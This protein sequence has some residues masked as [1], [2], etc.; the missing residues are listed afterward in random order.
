LE[1]LRQGEAAAFRDVRQA[2]AVLTLVFG[3]VLPTYRAHHADLLFH[4]REEDLFQP[5]FLAR[6][7]EAV[8]AQR[9]PWE[10]A[11]RIVRGSLR[12]L[13]DY[14]GHRPIAILESRPKG[15]PYEHERVRPIP[16]FLRGAGVAWGPYQ[17]LIGRALEILN[18]TDPDLLGEACLD[19]AVLDELAFDPRAYDFGHP[20]EK[21]PNYC[22]GEWDPHHIDNQGRYRR[23]VLRQLTLDALLDRIARPGDRQGDEL[24]FEA[25]A[26]LSGTM[27]MAAGVSGAGPETHDSSITLSKLVPRIARYREAFYSRLFQG[28]TGSHGERLRA[29]AKLTR[30]PFGGA[31]QHLNQYLA[32]QRAFQLQQ[33]QLALLFAEIGDAAA[34]RRQVEKIAVA[35]V[36]VLTEI[37][38]RL[39]TGRLL[40]ERGEVM[41]AAGLLPEVE[42]LLQRGIACGALADPWNILGFQGQFPRFTSLEDSVRDSRIDDLVHV[43]GNLFSLYAQVLSEGA[44]R[45]VLMPPPDPSRNLQQLAEWWDHFATLEVSDVP[46]VHG[47]EAAVSAEHVARALGQW[48][49]QGANAGD[50]AFWREHLGGFRSPKAFALVV[51]ALLQKEDHRA[52]MALLMTWLGQAEQIPLEDSG[53]SF[54]TLAVRWMLGLWKTA[55]ADRAAS[56]QTIAKFFDYL[57]ANAEEYW[58]VPR[59]DVAG[60]GG[61]PG[62]TAQPEREPESL[63]SAAYEDVTYRDTTDDDVEGEVLDFM[64]Q[65]DFD[66]GA[67]SERLEKHLRFLSTLAR[68]WNIATRALSDPETGSPPP[69]GQNRIATWSARARRNSQ[70]L[71]ALLDRVHAHEIPKPPGSYEGLVEYDR[72]RIIKERL[73]GQIIA[74]CLDTNLATGAMQGA[75]PDAATEPG[76][77]PAWEPLALRLERAMW[78]GDVGGARVLVPDFIQQFRPE[79][80]LYTPLN[81]G[82]HPRLVLRASLAQVILRAL[83][84]NLPRLGL[85]RETA[86]LIRAARTMEQEQ[87]LQGPRVTEFDRLFQG[88]CQAVTEAVVTSVVGEPASSLDAQVTKQQADQ[89]VLALE[90]LLEPFL[91]MWMEHTRSLRVSI[92]E[93]IA[94]DAEWQKTCEFIQKY[95]RDLF[96]ARFM[97]LGNLRG[98]LHRGVGTFLDYLRDNPDPLHP[99]RL[100]EELEKGLPR[101]DVERH[102]QFVV[103]AIV[104]NY[105]EYRDYN[106]TTTQSDFGENL[107]QLLGFLRLKARYERNAWLLRPLG[108]AHEILARR[109]PEAACS[110]RQQVQELTSELADDHLDEL[111]ELEERHGMHLRTV[112]DR[113]HERFLQPLEQDRLVALI[114]P[115]MEQA[116][117]NSSPEVS[118]LEKELAP[119]ADTPTGAGLDV[120]DWLARL[121]AEVQRV[122]GTHTALADLADTLFQIPR[123]RVPLEELRRQ[124]KDWETA[125]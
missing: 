72:R 93:V 122:R 92:L 36:R 25:A 97:T 88:A 47:S 76:E 63:Y 96:H 79:P 71:L 52:A 80:L 42:E 14:V 28:R 68:L 101:A 105:E 67:E 46:H 9:G 66:L 94:T 82:G 35:S 6:V 56:A 43:V 2:Q 57:E 12:Q 55:R 75:L 13:N 37:H 112:A 74:T 117:V 95:G 10:D 24:L 58:N 119:F 33:R 124:L 118:P 38:L 49:D 87:P 16:L 11:P 116:Q 108:L 111:A 84:V 125:T 86:L 30:Q 22:F 54:H 53:Y 32:R 4:Q 90:A 89:I 99:V 3:E 104:E 65:K 83:A 7:F 5:Y 70:D 45:G 39:T 123:L 27:L 62:E 121:R 20:A 61:E 15:E 34:S 81:Q 19:P 26:V 44:A 98:I 114:E 73:L 120:P 109:H 103:Q 17:E 18:A 91:S 31:R 113:L 107:H 100:I 41:K 77:R 29:E 102:L 50:L 110:W 1:S 48:R 51:E 64:P 78:H 21:R 106:A 69:D 23:F 60:I 85:I 115:A 59:L 8:L 40:V